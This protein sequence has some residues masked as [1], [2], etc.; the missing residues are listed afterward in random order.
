MICVRSLSETGL[1][2]NYSSRSGV[3]EIPFRLNDSPVADMEVRVDPTCSWERLTPF[4]GCGLASSTRLPHK[5]S[6]TKNNAP[7]DATP[8]K[9]P[10]PSINTFAKTGEFSGE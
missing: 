1:L 7:A 9:N 6:T 3:A 5:H 4:G 10:T 2:A 8:P